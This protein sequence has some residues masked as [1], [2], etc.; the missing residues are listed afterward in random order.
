MNLNVKLNNVNISPLGSLT[1]YNPQ[2]V[3]EIEWD[4][5]NERYYAIELKN[6][7]TKEIHMFNINL[8]GIFNNFENGYETVKLKYINRSGYY[9][10]TLYEQNEWQPEISESTY[11]GFIPK[12]TIDFYI[13]CKFDSEITKIIRG[14]LSKY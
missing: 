8:P 11:Y 2:Q 10:L 9:R 13:N 12:E 4:G 5:E 6:N 7:K 14:I 3:F 1:I